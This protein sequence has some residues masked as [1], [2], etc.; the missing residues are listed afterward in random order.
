MS[1]AVPVGE[2]ATFMCAANGEPVPTITW[3]FIGP[4]AE[5]EILLSSDE[6]YDITLD[7]NGVSTL[8]VRS[9]EPSDLGDYIC[10]A[11]NIYDSDSAS[12]FLQPL[13]EQVY[14]WT[15]YMYCM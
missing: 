11:T 7:S 12:A 13:G 3:Y 15:A 1:V 5:V 6:K 4:I 8:V 10:V 2:D 9:V 14:M